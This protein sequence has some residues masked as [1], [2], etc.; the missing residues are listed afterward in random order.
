MNKRELEQDRNS[1]RD[2]AKARMEHKI[3]MEELKQKNIE[4]KQLAVQ[5]LE[6]KQKA[7]NKALKHKEKLENHFRT[8]IEDYKKL[9]KEF[10]I[11]YVQDFIK[12]LEKYFKTLKI[13]YNQCVYT[14]D[15][16]RLIEDDFIK[17]YEY[18]FI[19]VFI[20][21]VSPLDKELHKVYENLLQECE[22][23][24]TFCKEQESILFYQ[25]NIEKEI[26]RE[27]LLWD[28]ERFFAFNVEYKESKQK[29]NNLLI[30]FDIEDI[31]DDDFLDIADNEDDIKNYVY[32]NIY[33]ISWR[34]FGYMNI[35]DTIVQKEKV[36]TDTTQYTKQKTPIEYE[37]YIASKLK[38]IGFDTRVTKGS[39]DQGVDV[40]AVRAGLSF[41]IQCKMYS[42]PVGNSAVQE[43]YAGKEF[44]NTNYGV[45]VTNASFTK[46]ARQLANKNH[47]ILLHDTQLDE[48]LRYI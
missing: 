10:R 19:N 45:V 5:Q 46:S 26:L 37:R 2:M 41:A 35:L 25:I 40:L 4:K 47:I 28:V 34:L 44:Y 12:I 18:F 23:I 11:K 22:N 39:G 1:K 3:R 13:K 33:N 9:V 24:Y 21:E 43:V 29:E 14:D 38:G 30:G 42:H 17:E 36:N 27:L 48:L 16:G 7:L 6:E 31:T 20:K 8:S 15:Y 32:E